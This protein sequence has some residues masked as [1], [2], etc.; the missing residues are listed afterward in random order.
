MIATR[1]LIEHPE[2]TG[3]L[4]YIERFHRV[5]SLPHDETLRPSWWGSFLRWHTKLIRDDRSVVIADFSATV[6]IVINKKKTIKELSEFL[7]SICNYKTRR[8]KKWTDDDWKTTQ[9]DIF[10]YRKNQTLES[11]TPTSHI[12][13]DHRWPQQ[14]LLALMQNNLI[15][16]TK[17][18]ISPV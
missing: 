3:E 2:G 7:Q 11:G 9:L 10:H 8:W 1:H 18:E 14:D 6:S 12:D 16:C 15:L 13:F 4:N 5:T 17:V